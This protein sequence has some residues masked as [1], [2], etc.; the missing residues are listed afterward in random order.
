MDLHKL[1]AE[2]RA[3]MVP[4]SLLSARDTATLAEH[5]EFLLGIED[6]LVTSF[7][8]TLYAHEPT[9]SVS[10]STASRHCG[11]GGGGPWASR[12]T[13]ATGRGWAWWA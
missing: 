5:A 3:E 6:A 4:T 7:Y 1:Q 8:D 12:S 2:I 13:T 9:P 11:C 10:G